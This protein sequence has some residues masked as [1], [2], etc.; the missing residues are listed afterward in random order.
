MPRG[1]PERSQFT[2]YVTRCFF[3]I[4]TGL[5]RRNPTTQPATKGARHYIRKPRS[6]HAFRAFS[7]VT[8]PTKRKPTTNNNNTTTTRPTTGQRRRHIFIVH[9]LAEI[10]DT[11]KKWTFFVFLQNTAPWRKSRLPSD[12]FYVRALYTYFGRK[13]HRECSGAQK[14]EKIIFSLFFYGF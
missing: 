4:L 14:Y 1:W 10:L 8:E 3:L 7:R 2:F 12:F 6:N 13:L 5:A 9:K 11:F